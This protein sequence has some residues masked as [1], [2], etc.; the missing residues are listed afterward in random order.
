[1]E[2]DPNDE[3]RFFQETTRKFLDTEMPVTR[4]RE[5]AKT[6]DGFDRAWWRRGAELGWTSLLVRETDGGGTLSGNGTSDLAI[7][8]EEFGRSVAPGPL[9]PLNICAQTISLLGTDTQRAEVL[10]GLLDGSVIATWCFHESARPWNVLGQ[11]MQATLDVDGGWLLT[12]TK[13]AVEYG[14]QADWLLVSVGTSDNATTNSGAHDRPDPTG[15]PP[16]GPT[17]FLLRADTPGV[18]ITQKESIDLVRRYA[19]IRFDH[20]K[21]NPA[22]VVGQ[23]NGAAEDIERQIATAVAL[24]CAEISGAAGK[25]FE[26]TLAYAFDRFSFGRP[27]ASYQALKHRF[28]DMK[29]WLESSYA[30]SLAAAHAVG[31]NDPDAS[32][33][34]SIAKAYVADR[35][36][37]LIQD[38][39]QMHGGIGVTWEHDLHLYLRRVTADA[40]TL[41]TPDDHRERVAA[42]CG[43]ETA[44]AR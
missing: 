11:T 25:V 4:V 33:L 12:G 40:G 44:G 9:I 38:C 42:A 15:G 26:F 13:T 8:A 18:T 31:A 37:E 30:T 19:D 7:V 41:G 36:P 5:L 27:L 10:P 3:Q 2:L 20:V 6:Q 16:H 43:L 17:Q 39:I 14:A 22:A 21:C 32:K 34:A 23:P 29:T 28:A 35:C 1:V 24:Q